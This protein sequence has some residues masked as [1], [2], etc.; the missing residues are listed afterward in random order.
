MLGFDA[1]G[2]VVLGSIPQSS[3]ISFLFPSSYVET[4]SFFSPNVLRGTVSLFPT[5]LSEADVFGTHNLIYILHAAY[6]SDPDQFFPATVHA[7][8]TLL[9]GR[10][11]SLNFFGTDKIVYW[12]NPNRYD[13]PDNIYPP[14][15]RNLNTLRPPFYQDPDFIGS[16]QVST[17]YTL[18]PAFVLNENQFFPFHSA[19]FP[20]I[21][22]ERY[23]D[24]NKVRTLKASGAPIFTTLRRNFI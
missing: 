17:S 8:K 9:P 13:D 20:S 22:K 10:L 16:H 19:S 18:N 7:S 14:T 23:F 4:N 12:V 1:L 15:S 6:L 5:L 21:S 2:T 11:S 24:P 3:N